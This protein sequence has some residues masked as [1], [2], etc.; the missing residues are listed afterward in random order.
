MFVCESVCVYSNLWQ[1]GTVPGIGIIR[2][3]YIDSRHIF[4]KPVG[5]QLCATPSSLS[6]AK[7]CSPKFR[8]PCYLMQVQRILASFLPS[9]FGTPPHAS[10]VS[11]SARAT[12]LQ[13]HLACRKGKGVLHR[14]SGCVKG[15]GRELQ[16]Q[17]EASNTILGL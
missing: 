9:S 10:A 13:R 7:Y 16:K 12:W 11:Y 4:S 8:A 14:L 5:A 6:I 17:I 15:P 2:F 3:L 1:P